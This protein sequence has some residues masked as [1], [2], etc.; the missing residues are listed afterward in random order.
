MP[1]ILF[2]FNAS[3]K[4]IVTT[5]PMAKRALAEVQVDTYIADVLYKVYA[6]DRAEILVGAGV[7]I[8][9]ISAE[10]ETRVFVEDQDRTSQRG[11]S[12]L[13][14]PLP[15]LRLQG[16]YA[17][18]PKWALSATL[19]WLS[20]TYDEYDGNFSYVHARTTYN[21]TDHFGVSLGYQY[22][23]LDFTRDRDRGETGIEASFDGPSV[24]LTYGF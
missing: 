23:D 13:L 18:T 6:S 7:H 10:I 4:C 5:L 2:I 11:G 20:I 21:F 16:F 17:L 8:L 3:Y 22:V 24:V 19:G 14:A 9:D 15:N 12:D 1:S